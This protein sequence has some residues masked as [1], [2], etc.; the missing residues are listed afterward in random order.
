MNLQ[1][2]N[3]LLGISGGIASYKACELVR[4]LRDAGAEVRVVMT[5]NATRFITPLTLQALSGHP[6]RVSLWDEN[7]EAAMGHIELARWADAIL[8]APASAD[9]MARLAAGMADD[10]LTTLCLASEAPMLLAPAMN[11]IM[12][13][14]PATQANAQTLHQRGAS[15]LGPA[16]GSQACG[17]TGEG[18]MLEAV[19]LVKQLADVLACRV[20][21]RSA[22]TLHGK[23]VVITAGATREAIDPVRFISNRSSG[24]MGYA[25][26]EAARD[27]GAEVVL[28]SGVTHLPTP[29]GIRRIDVETALQMRTA[30]LQAMP[31]DIFI[32]TAA[33][34]D[35]RPA[36]PATQKIKK[37]ADT[38]S[39]ELIKNPD[40]LSEVAA[41]ERRPFS[42]GFAAETEHLLEHARDKLQ[43]KNL[44][45]IAANRVG[46]GLAFDQLDNALSVLW[47]DGQ[48]EL[49]HTDKSTLARQLIQIITER[50]ESHA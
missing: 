3:I 4:R 39:I 23:R 29:P 25:V 46:E 26:A 48:I 7:H 30:V 50:L 33:V 49:A 12:W 2:K 14:H 20:D 32:A 6:V 13:A 18:R 43:R 1:H 41:L 9:V 38:L 22:S 36:D 34:A 21:K 31:C 16:A 47:A 10:L 27:A 28:I 42:V 45:L 8:I 35:Y 24:R 17:E 11:R 5:D 37:H 44:D 15:I 19:D 40:I